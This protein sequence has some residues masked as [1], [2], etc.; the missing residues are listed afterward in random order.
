MS[1]MSKYLNTFSSQEVKLDHRKVGHHLFFSCILVSYLLV[2]SYQGQCYH[3]AYLIDFALLQNGWQNQFSKI[4]G[5]NI[6]FSLKL[7]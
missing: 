1:M 5:L 6:F 4:F 3:E 2:L 7:V